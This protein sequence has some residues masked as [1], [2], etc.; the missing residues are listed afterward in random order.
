[1]TKAIN[2]RQYG[3]IIQHYPITTLRCH[4]VVLGMLCAL[5]LALSMAGTEAFGG[6]LEDV[7]KAGKLRHLGIPYARTCS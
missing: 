3:L 5:I 4:S 6:D 7:Y 1:M 2:Q